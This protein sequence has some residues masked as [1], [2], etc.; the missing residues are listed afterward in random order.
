MMIEQLQPEEHRHP[1]VSVQPLPDGGP[2]S[3]QSSHTIPHGSFICHRH[4]EIQQVSQ[5][6]L[7]L[8]RLSVI[9]KVQTRTPRVIAQ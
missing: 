4:T 5:I 8:V 3:T 1:G 6:A 2:T 7:C 9:S